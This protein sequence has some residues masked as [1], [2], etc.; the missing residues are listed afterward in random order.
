MPSTL[1]KA[2]QL[3]LEAYRIL[4]GL[5]QNDDN[6]FWRRTDI[7]L[8]INGGML[9]AIGLMA[10]LQNAATSLR[11]VLVAVCFV[12]VIVCVF[13]LFIA[14]RSEAFYNHWYEQL[15]FLER[16]YL[17]PMKIFQI[18]DEFFSKGRVKLGS[19]EFKLGFLARTVHMF[20]A[21]QILSVVFSFVWAL[22]GV[23]L[24]F[25]T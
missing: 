20:V 7:L 15:K 24:L 8:A 21:M 3:Q 10:K 16:K 25:H 14:R 22:L 1:S 17:A 4:T 23:Y 5:L 11:A 9:T 19:E 2:Q 18:A 12:G 6:L 13:W